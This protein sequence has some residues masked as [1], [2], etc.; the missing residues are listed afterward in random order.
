MS[1]Y[2]LTPNL[3]LIK[4]NYNQDTEQW[5]YHLN[6][7]SETLDSLLA[8][9]LAGA[10]Y[11]PVASGPFLPLAG[12]HMDN[13]ASINLLRT[14]YDSSNPVPTLANVWNFKGTGGL[15]TTVDVQSLNYVSIDTPI[16]QSVWANRD[17][18]INSAPTPSLTGA[19]FIARVMQC[20]SYTD[21][22]SDALKNPIMWAAIS[23]GI[24]WTGHPS[25]VSGRI[26][27]HEF[28]IA[29]AGL[30]DAP[31]PGSLL[32][33]G[34]SIVIVSAGTTHYP[35]NPMSEFVTAIGVFASDDGVRYK[36]MITFGAPFNN[37]GLDFR[38]ATS[39]GGAPAIWLATGHSIAFDSSKNLQFKWQEDRHRY[40][41]QWLGNS[42]F[43]I[44]PPGNVFIGPGHLNC[45]ALPFFTGGISFQGGDNSIGTIYTDGNYGCLIRGRSG[46]I[47][48]V[49]LET[50]DGTIGFMMASF[51]VGFNGKT[52]FAKPTVTGSIT[53]QTAAVLAEIV[54]ALSNYGLITKSTTP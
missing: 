6:I 52:P 50:S 51:G 15:N 8:D 17:T 25:S 43:A 40:E 44:D 24:D 26:L 20:E 45:S 41:F 38:S 46:A 36:N 2:T 10:P 30:D 53:T 34:R 28:D 27:V 4:P 12:G 18:I 48:D 16:G 31:N 39:L 29:A 13:G 19:S 35:V 14:T 21:R 9:L 47:A 42:T 54:D 22:G 5:G 49:A 23:N 3:G 11:I 7:N 32:S 33:G 37:A 1:A